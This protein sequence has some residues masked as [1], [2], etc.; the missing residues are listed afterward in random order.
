MDSLGNSYYTYKGELIPILLR[1][2]QSTEEEGTFPSSF[3]ETAITLVPKPNK[4]TIKK[5][6]EEDDDYS[7][8]SP[9]NID[10][11]SSTKYYQTESN[12]A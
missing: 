10:V 8:I 12:N 6:K 3:S 2:F 1:L 9:M 4:D 11:K 5:K 7:Q